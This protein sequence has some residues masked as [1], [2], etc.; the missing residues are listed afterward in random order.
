MG[1]WLD[2]LIEW[3]SLGLWTASLLLRE[4]FLLRKMEEQMEKFHDERSEYLRLI[5]KHLSETKVD[6]A[7]YR[8]K[9]KP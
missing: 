2:A 3:G 8:T 7:F 6:D 1:V 4:K 5:S 9:R